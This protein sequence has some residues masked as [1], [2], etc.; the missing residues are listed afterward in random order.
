MN[1]RTI[2]LLVVA[3]G[4][5]GLTAM[6][7]RNWISA[8]R[9]AMLAGAPKAAPQAARTHVLVADE[10]VPAGTFVTEGHLRWQPWPQDGLAAG[11]AVQGKCKIEDFIGAVA[12]AAITA[13]EP[14]TDA[15][16]VH[17][18]DR[19]FLAAVLGAGKRAVSVPVN[20]TTGVAG[21]VFPG[22]WVD[23]IL[24]MRVRAE[25]EDGDNQNRYFS[26]TLLHDIRVL[27]VDQAVERKD[28]Q[29]AVAKTATVEVMP[30]Q[31]EKIALALEMG[32]LS[33]SLLSLS[34]EQDRFAQIARA[35]GAD[36][37]EDAPAKSYT[38]DTDI[39]YMRDGLNGRGSTAPDTGHQVNILRGKEAEQATF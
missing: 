16:V 12:R 14:I 9:A 30:K 3:L 23:V 31:A 26:K 32:D 6:F 29:V 15:R 2:L 17:P 24:T 39:Y 27:A 28:G 33:L 5:A 22:D 7:A 25:D 4:V 21:F 8:E 20:A 18:G 38:L 35:I 37:E 10:A 19:G 34:R 36:P 11:F 1:L 13:G